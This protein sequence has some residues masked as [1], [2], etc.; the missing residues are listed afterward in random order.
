MVTKA[1]ISKNIS[2]EL[3]ISKK[4]SKKIFEK[5]ISL[6]I[7]KSTKQN[8]KI[9]GFG[10]FSIHQTPKRVGRN[11]KTKES[12]IIMPMNKLIF[13]ASEKVKEVLN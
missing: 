2:N 1:S 7:G 6:I 9:H 5:F 11:P 3:N 10:V 4:E 13:K 12:Y 8:V